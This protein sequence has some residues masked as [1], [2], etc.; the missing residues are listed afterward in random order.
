M[1]RSNKHPFSLRPLMILLFFVVLH[2]C[3]KTD[4]NSEKLTSDAEKSLKTQLSSLKPAAESADVVYQWY[5]FIANIQLPITP[6]P[7][8]FPQARAFAYIGIGLFESVQPGIE[9][10]SSFASK[11]NEMPAMPQPDKSKRYLWTASANAAMSRMFKLFL[12]ILSAT[13]KAAI[14]A[15]EAD[16]YNQLKQTTSEDVLKRSES[17]G[18]SIADAI[19][20]WSTTDKFSV[21]SG[22]YTPLNQ[23][24]AWIPTPPNFPNAVGDNLQYSRPLLKYTLKP[25]IEAPPVPYSEDPNSAFYKAAMEVY[26]IGGATTATPDNK[27][28]AN[29]WA[30]AGGPGKGVPAPYHILSVVTSV[31][32]SQHAGLW[33]AAEVYAKTGIA[34]KD[35]PINTF[36]AKYQYT[37]LRPATYIRRHIEVSWLPHLINPPYPEYPSGLVG[38]YGPVVQ[39]L[40]KTFGNIPATDDVYAWRAVPARHF[41]SLS[42]LLAEAAVSRVYAGIHYRFTQDASILINIALGNEIARVQVVGPK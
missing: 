14:D 23:P 10:G 35:G 41:N 29:W 26:N 36:R 32:E 12:P 8:V 21:S 34:L 6:Q 4:I 33:K 20:N 18:R 1:K 27:A 19:Y 9:G 15:R 22:T 2:S 25:R 16:I 39:V 17:F 3:K 40:I 37:L 11:L 7:S 30:D 42:Q 38:L 31:L 28:T 13:E 24:W 5:K